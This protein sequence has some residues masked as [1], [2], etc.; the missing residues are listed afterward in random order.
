LVCTSPA[1][2]L[3]LC[4]T[5]VATF[6][7]PSMWT[8]PILII[9]ALLMAGSACRLHVVGLIRNKVAWIVYLGAGT[10]RSVEC[11]TILTQDS[12][13]GYLRRLLAA[14]PRSYSIYREQALGAE[15][16]V[17]QPERSCRPF[18]GDQAGYALL[19]PCLSNGC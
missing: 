9:H 15:P 16:Q 19:F 12:S 17:V 2:R 13:F 5:L 18:I 10:R 1:L 7:L 4:K 8:L 6:A 11:L 3:K 14:L